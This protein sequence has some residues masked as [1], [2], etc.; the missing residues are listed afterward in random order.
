M[1]RILMIAGMLALGAC[2]A[3]PGSEK[4]CEQ[5]KEQ[6]KTEW[7][8]SDA[9]TFASNCLLDSTTIGSKEWCE[10]MSDKP[11]G[12][13]TADETASYTKHCII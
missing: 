12:Q 11:K 2:S 5:K 1:R 8:S 6:S 10:D 3:E 4:W 9:I 7:S 13:W